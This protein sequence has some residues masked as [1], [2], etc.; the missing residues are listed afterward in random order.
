M[1]RSQ[2]LQIPYPIS[3]AP[4]PGRKSITIQR[5]LVESAADMSFDD[6]VAVLQTTQ[7]PETVFVLC[8]SDPN[9]AE[10][11]NDTRYTT[12]VDS[13]GNPIS[14]MDNA[15]LGAKCLL[16]LWLAFVTKSGGYRKTS[17]LL[18]K[19]PPYRDVTLYYLKALAIGLQR[20]A[21][22]TS[23][24]WKITRYYLPFVGRD[25][26]IPLYG[27]DGNPSSL[28]ELYTI[29]DPTI[30]QEVETEKVAV[31]SPMIPGSLPLAEQQRIRSNIPTYFV[32][33]VDKQSLF[34]Y[35][36]SQR[37]R[38]RV[39]DTCRRQYDQIADTIKQE[40]NITGPTQCMQGWLPDMMNVNW[41]VKFMTDDMYTLF[42]DCETLAWPKLL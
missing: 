29:R 4:S 34:E 5:Q 36:K 20:D 40:R 9:L 11:C 24:S 30:L 39:L 25:V 7:N 33:H 26:M 15:V 17:D 31:T 27:S 19:L 38:D 8:K 12:L 1:K 42:C 14:I 21:C 2:R 10:I 23:E 16:Y 37:F 13:R 32:E 28:L 6:K 18:S 3:I 35:A 22:T 41:Y